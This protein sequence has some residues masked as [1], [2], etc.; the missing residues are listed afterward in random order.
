MVATT[1]PPAEGRGDKLNLVGLEKSD[2]RGAP[3]TLCQGC[4]HDSIS[5]QII[6]VAFEL[7]LR[8]S[9]IIKMSGIGC[10]S[11]SPAYFMNRSHGFNAVHG[12]MPSVVTGAALANRSVLPIAVSGDGDT[13]SIGMGQYKHVV[14]RNVPMVYIIENNGVYG[15]TKGQ[16]SATADMGQKLKYA[17]LNELPPIDLCMEAITAG[18]GFVA[19]SFAG[20]A[21]QVRELLK[22]A[23]NYR[24]TA[25]LDIISPCVTFNNHEESTKSYPYGKANEE[26]IHDISF[27]EKFDEIQ[28]DYDPGTTINVQLHNGPAIQLKKLERDYDPTNKISAMKLLVEAEEKQEFITGLI[29][30]DT[31]RATIHDI[32]D[33]PEMPLAQLPNEALRPSREALDKIMAGLA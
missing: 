20:D 22:A 23:M 28:V 8:P 19:R 30:I 16:F 21:K 4:G 13:G 32:L 11:K 29:Y 5:S 3:S 33:L 12:R 17:G 15:L 27:I 26:R 31:S 9:E 2:Y 10:S 24:G 7:S 18:C 6:N 14:R 25:V 1:R